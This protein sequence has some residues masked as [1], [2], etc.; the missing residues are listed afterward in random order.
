MLAHMVAALVAPLL[1]R[2][3]G[4]GAFYPLAVVPAASAVWLATF[5][6]RTLGDAPV[7]VSVPWIPAFGIDLAFRLDTLSWVLGLIAT[8]IGAMVLRCTARATSRT[9]SLG[10]AASPACSPPSPARWW[11]WSWPTTSWWSTPSG[12]SPPSSPICWWATTRTSRPPA[13]RR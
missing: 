13:V 7:E 12:S 2:W 5:D 4:R 11:V 6:P 9:P 3:I 8:G 1:V 10:W